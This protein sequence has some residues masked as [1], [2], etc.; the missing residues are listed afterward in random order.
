MIQDQNNRAAGTEQAEEPA[1]ISKQ[2]VYHFREDSKTKVKR[3]SITSNILVPTLTGLADIYGNENQVGIKKVLGLIQDAITAVG[4]DWLSAN[5]TAT[6]LP[7]EFA[8]FDYFAS[9]PDSERAARGIAKEIWEAFSRDYISVMPAILG[10]KDL[11]GNPDPSKAKLHAKLLIDQRVAEVKTNKPVLGQLRQFLHAYAN[12]P[13]AGTYADCIT[14]L[15]E[16][17]EGFLNT[18]EN[19]LLNNIM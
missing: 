17:I 18:D 1:N 12:T 6:T 9:I 19:A 15:D 13:N 7:P 4:R 3:P 8:N 14:V 16:K 11:N 10:H 5:P 2:V